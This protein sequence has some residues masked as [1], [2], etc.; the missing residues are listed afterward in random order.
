[1]VITQRGEDAIQASRY[2]HSFSPS[3]DKHPPFEAEEPSNLDD[4]G[5]GHPGV[6]D[7]VSYLVLAKW[8]TPL[9]KIVEVVAMDGEFRQCFVRPSEANSSEAAPI[10]F[11]HLR[12]GVITF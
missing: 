2:Q 3:A 10:L 6:D 5:A 11:F 8:S 9:V 1:M 4:G 12:I 7:S